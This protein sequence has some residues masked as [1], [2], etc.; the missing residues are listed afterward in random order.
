M[1]KLKINKKAL[2]KKTLEQAL[3]DENY[4]SAAAIR[5]LLPTIPDDE[6]IEVDDEETPEKTDEEECV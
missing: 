1:A 6:I 5:D 2:Y 3:A 4:E